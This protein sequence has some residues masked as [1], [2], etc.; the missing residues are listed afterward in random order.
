[1]RNAAETIVNSRIII[2]DDSPKQLKN[3]Y[4]ILRNAS[5]DVQ[6]ATTGELA[7][8]YVNSSPPDLIMLDAR[9]PGIDG[10]EVCGKLKSNSKTSNIPVIF[11]NEFE[12]F[13]D[14]PLCFQV[15]AAAYL[16]KPYDPQEVLSCVDANLRLSYLSKRLADLNAE[17]IGSFYSNVLTGGSEVFD[18]LK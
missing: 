11:L 2:V 14:K 3:L 5:Y 12:N 7:L 15:G 9:M 16:T 8:H 4:R 13:P 6:V 10:F 18:Q 17:A 1:M